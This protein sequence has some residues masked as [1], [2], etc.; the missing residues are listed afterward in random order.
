KRMSRSDAVMPIRDSSGKFTAGA[1]GIGGTAGVSVI[2][3]LSDRLSRLSGAAS[4]IEDADPAVKAAREVAEPIQRSFQF[5]RGDKQSSWLK[6]ILT[7]LTAF[8]KEESVYNRSTKDTLEKIERK[9]TAMASGISGFP[10]SS[11]LGIGARGLLGAGKGLLRKVPLIGAI[12]T[13]IGSIFD[14]FNSESSGLSRRDKDK[15]AGSVIGGTAGTIGGAIAGAMAGAVAGPVGMVIGGIVGSFLGDQAGQIIGDTFGGWVNDLRNAD[16]PGKIAAAWDSAVTAM[17]ATFNE[18]WSKV[19]DIGGLVMNV[20]GEQLNDVNSY[21]KANTG[22]DA[23]QLGSEWWDRTKANVSGAVDYT[24]QAASSLVDQA[25]QS[26]DWAAKN[27]TIGKA[28]SKAASTVKGGEIGSPERAMQLLME[29]G[30]SKDDAAAIAANLN[31]ESRFDTRASGDKG[32]AIGI[33]QWH[34]DR[35][36]QFEKVF[37]KELTDASFEEQIAFIDWEMNNTNKKAGMA[38]RSAFG[39]DSK[40]AAVEQFYERSALGQ[41]GGV[42]P[43]R[44]ADARKYAAINVSGPSV[45]LA[46]RA[47]AMPKIAEPPPIVEPLLSTES[48][49]FTVNLPTQDVG[50]NL[51]DRRIAHIASGGI[52]NF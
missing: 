2:S 13:S 37:G 43:E 50:Q 1:S 46:P 34:Q 9:P 20:V 26:V 36:A 33:A 10:I 12:L 11:L 22:V 35:Q 39:V 40:T 15:Y 31:S 6:K 32:T 41:R 16:I 51:T 25:M 52:S 17:S 23:K 21:V 29:K 18:A 8:H 28:F 44:I 5:F 3:S 38:I 45:A 49:Q 42:Q 27:T 19:K 14:I 4:G 24:K 47:P 48:P 7:K 30:W